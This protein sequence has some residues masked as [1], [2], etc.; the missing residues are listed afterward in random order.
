MNEED[1]GGG[2]GG[3]PKPPNIICRREGEARRGVRKSTP[4]PQTR[5]KK[6]AKQMWQLKERL[7]NLQIRK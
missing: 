3:I 4:Q 2:G 5:N 6:K 1:T 7:G